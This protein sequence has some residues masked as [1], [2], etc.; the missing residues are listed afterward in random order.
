MPTLNAVIQNFVVG[1][2]LLLT[3]TIS[4]IDPLD[5]LA[6][7]VFSVKRY[8]EDVDGSA[9]FTKTITTAQVAGQGQIVDTGSTIDGNGI[10]SLLFE[11]TSANT[12]RLVSN[13]AYAFDIS[14]KTMAGAIYTPETGIIIGSSQISLAIP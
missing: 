6:S 8:R 4:N 13:C 1:D 7:A 2:S 10:A 5:G 3:R 14:V 11:L 12:G 9:I